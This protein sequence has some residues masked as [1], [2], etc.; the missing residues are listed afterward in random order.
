MAELDGVR[1]DADHITTLALV[2]YAHYTSMRV[3]DLRVRGLSRYLERLVRD[4]R[5][6]FNA[7]LEPDQVRRLIQRALTDG[8]RSIVVRVTVFDPALTSATPAR[9]P[10]HT[11][12]SPPDRPHSPRLLQ[13][14]SNQPATARSY[15]PSNTQG[16]SVRCGI[17]A[18]RSATASTMC[19][20]PMPT[21]PSPKRPPRTAETRT[22]PVTLGQLAEVDAAFITNAVVGVRPIAAIDGIQLSA[23]HPTVTTLEKHYGDIPPEPV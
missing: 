23:E 11:C 9:R 10:S 16:C 20:S 4:C 17:G 3:E 12:S 18:S 6:V 1:V 2:N 7:E 22:A 14:A 15:Q 5:W 19:C 8:P 13:C 21:P